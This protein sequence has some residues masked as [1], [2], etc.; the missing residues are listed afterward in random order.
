FR[1]LGF[2]SLTA[3]NLRNQLSAR[4]GLKL[5][6]TLVFDHPTPTA[7][8]EFLRGEIG[9]AVRSQEGAETAV[10]S[11]LDRLEAGLAGLDGDEGARQ[12]ITSRLRALVT[13]LDGGPAPADATADVADR[14]DAASAEE[15]LAFIDNEFGE[16]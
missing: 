15:V 1:D 11:E 4:T 10:L 16:A 2:E 14:L 12:R 7:L 3:V 6:V 13:R 9:G 8:A 5:P